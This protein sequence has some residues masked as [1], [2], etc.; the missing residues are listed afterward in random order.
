MS[1]DSIQQEVYYEQ[2]TENVNIEITD[3]QKKVYEQPELPATGAKVLKFFL[4]KDGLTEFEKSEVL[5]YKQCY[6]LGLGS[7]K[8]K[9]HKNNQYNF[10]YDD[11]RGDYV[12]VI[13]DQIAFRFQVL[14]FLG[15]GSFGQALKCFDHKT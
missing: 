9:G 3:Q 4:K 11:E 13:G 7:D 1:D 12:V 8:V 5:D 14:D 6:Y 10:G 15:K 2:K